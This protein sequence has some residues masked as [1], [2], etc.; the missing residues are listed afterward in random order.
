MAGFVLPV[1]G[2]IIAKGGANYTSTMFR[3]LAQLT[4]SGFSG[5]RKGS[6]LYLRFKGKD[7]TTNQVISSTLTIRKRSKDR[8]DIAIQSTDPQTGGLFNV[9][10]IDFRGG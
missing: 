9:G 10:V 1:D 6:R 4:T 2:S 5:R 8:F 7:N 3:T